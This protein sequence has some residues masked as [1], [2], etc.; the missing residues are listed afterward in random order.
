[1][2]TAPSDTK[3]P[4]GPSRTGGRREGHGP[5]VASPAQPAHPASRSLGGTPAGP[6]GR[7]A[8]QAVPL[9]HIAGRP[10]LALREQ[11]CPPEVRGPEAALPSLVSPGAVGCLGLLRTWRELHQLQGGPAPGW[12]PGLHA[13]PHQVAPARHGCSEVPGGRPRPTAGRWP[14][15]AGARLSASSSCVPHPTTQEAETLSPALQRR[16]RELREVK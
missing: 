8:Q 14:P 15:S 7:G 6:R 5:R 12:P 9:P 13:Q 3:H 10:E 2:A 1:M 11:A 16:K 4:G